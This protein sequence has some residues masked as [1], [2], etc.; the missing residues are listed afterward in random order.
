MST[1][2]H[3]DDECP[4]IKSGRWTHCEGHELEAEG[5]NLT[6]VDILSTV[7]YMLRVPEGHSILAYTRRLV[8]RADLADIDGNPK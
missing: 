2:T 6:C 5:F 4:N 3:R 1:L 7:R 8:R